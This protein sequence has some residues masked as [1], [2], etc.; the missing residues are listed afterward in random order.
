MTW[1]PG[2]RLIVWGRAIADVIRISLGEA[3]ELGPEDER[4]DLINWS[5]PEFRA[6]SAG[7]T[8]K[9]LRLERAFWRALDFISSRMHRKRSAVIL[10]VM[11]EANSH[12]L[13]AT[14][15]LRS[16]V[17]NQLVTELERVQDLNDEAH[18]I[19]LLQ[20]APLPSFAV[21]RN[22]R[23]LRV[24]GEFN[25]FLRIL[26]A[27]TGDAVRR[28]SLQINLETPVAQLFETLA[29]SGESCDCAMNIVLD[30]RVRRVR[31]RI[32]AVPPHDPTALVGYVIP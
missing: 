1:L 26:F 24:N 6:L 11:R 8:R 16:F 12:H 23:L 10:D 31:T 14:S 21:D 19:A 20:Q 25:H 32:V 4:D 3:F 9:G 22:K 28:H 29:S 13:N 2:G 27:E 18:H 15:A 17:A 30:T 5:T 7:D